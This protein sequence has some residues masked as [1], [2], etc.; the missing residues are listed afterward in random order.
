MEYRMLIVWPYDEEGRTLGEESWSST[1]KMRP[2]DMAETPEA[3][4]RYVARRRKAAA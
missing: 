3:F 1:S 4:R 2:V